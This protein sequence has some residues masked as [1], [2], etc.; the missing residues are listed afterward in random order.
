[1]AVCGIGQAGCPIPLLLWI[2]EWR[3]AILIVLESVLPA[4]ILPWKRSRQARCLPAETGWKPVLPVGIA[5][6]GDELEEA[7]GRSVRGE[8]VLV[9][10]AEDD[11]L[12]LVVGVDGEDVVFLDD[13]LVLLLVGEFV[14]D[15]VVGGIEDVGGAGFELLRLDRKSVV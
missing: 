4:W 6:K 5:A 14:N 1:M 10:G 12:D 3:T 11:H 9:A 7:A 2:T 13:P 15:G 8:E